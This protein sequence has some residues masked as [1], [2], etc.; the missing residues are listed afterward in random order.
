MGFIFIDGNLLEKTTKKDTVKYDYTTDNRLKG[1]YYT[2][3][4]SVEYEYDAMRRKTTRTQS[5]RDVKSLVVGHPRYKG[6]R[7]ITLQ[8][9]GILRKNI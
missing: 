9:L 4:S 8:R 2:D 1:V 3:G 7:I 5:Y 6:S